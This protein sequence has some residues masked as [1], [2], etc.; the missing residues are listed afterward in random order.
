[1]QCNA[2]D[3]KDTACL[4]SHDIILFSNTNTKVYLINQVVLQVFLTC[5]MR[6]MMVFPA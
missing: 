4:V 2:N 1:M 3:V 5:E 6:G